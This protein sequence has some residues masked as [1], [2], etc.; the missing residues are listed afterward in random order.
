MPS[1]TTLLP[2]WPNPW[3]TL[4]EVDKW[5][6]DASAAPLQE[7]NRLYKPKTWIT[8]CSLSCK[9]DKSWN[10]WHDYC[11]CRR[12][13]CLQLQNLMLQFSR[14]VCKK[15]IQLTVQTK[16]PEEHQPFLRWSNSHRVADRGLKL[17]SAG[18]NSQH[19]NCKSTWPT[20]ECAPTHQNQIYPNLILAQKKRH[21][22]LKTPMSWGIVVGKIRR[23]DHP[24]LIAWSLK[25]QQ[26]LP[27]IACRD[28]AVGSQALYI[29][30]SSI[31]QAST[32]S[33][34]TKWKLLCIPK[35]RDQHSNHHPYYILL[36]KSKLHG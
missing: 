36:L 28:R 27:E 12:R 5:V 23:N 29:I 33:N 31:R 22:Q 3:S 1:Q 16:S 4:P 18:K 35:Y 9:A 11:N 26:G 8:K 10:H 21:L 25:D 19:A 30:S 24:H 2:S 13:W 15:S 7:L 32:P 20:R 17:P 14:G 34:L 6:T